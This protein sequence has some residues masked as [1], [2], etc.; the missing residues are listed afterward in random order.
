MTVTNADGGTVTCFGCFT[1]N[2]APTVATISPILYGP[3]GA[4]H[5]S[6]TVTGSGFQTGVGALIPVAA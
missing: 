5:Q 3:A 6:I 4:A 1:V 2:A